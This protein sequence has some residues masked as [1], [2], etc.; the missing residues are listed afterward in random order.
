LK[1]ELMRRF[2]WLR[3]KEIRNGD[4]RNF[5]PYVLPRYCSKV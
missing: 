1:S 2:I 3:L 5:L 4:A